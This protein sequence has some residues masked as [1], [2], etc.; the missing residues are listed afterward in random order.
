MKKNCTRSLPGSRRAFVLVEVM[1]GVAIFSIGILAL[2]EAVNNCIV[3][4]SVRA[5]DQR[6]RMALENEMAQIEAGMVTLTT[7]RSVKL[8]GTF[9]GITLNETRTPLSNLKNQQ[10]APV[11]NVY[12]IT[13]EASWQQGSHPQSK[14]ITFYGR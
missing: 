12:T 2:G 7:T 5:D 9:S 11:L 8:D 1:L 14:A 4:D 3:A 13:I 6:A 10:N